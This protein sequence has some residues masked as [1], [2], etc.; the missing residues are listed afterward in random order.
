MQG[1]QQLLSIQ[2]GR[3]ASNRRPLQSSR[4]IQRGEYFPV[5]CREGKIPEVHDFAPEAV[6]MAVSAGQLADVPAGLLKVKEK[7]RCL[8]SLP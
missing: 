7:V 2:H 8:G 3:F 6:A 5:V 1:E 4:A